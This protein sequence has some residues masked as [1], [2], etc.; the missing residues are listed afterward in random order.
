MLAELLNSLILPS[1]ALEAN[2]RAQGLWLP[3][4][5]TEAWLEAGMCMREKAPGPCAKWRPTWEGR[6]IGV[7]AVSGGA[8]GVRLASYG[9]DL[10]SLHHNKYA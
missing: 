10:S 9:V 4:I 2:T 7:G 8:A 6:C 1:P 3:L 5:W